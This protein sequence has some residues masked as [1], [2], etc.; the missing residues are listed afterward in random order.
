[1]GVC[2]GANIIKE[3]R[4]TLL[5]CLILFFPKHCDLLVCVC[6]G[7]FYRGN[8]GVCCGTICVCIAT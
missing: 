7:R 8:T 5:F 4:S 2:L 1:M 6:S 3:M